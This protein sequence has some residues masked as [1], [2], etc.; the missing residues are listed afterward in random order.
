MPRRPS[1]RATPARN[2]RGPA[3]P[4]TVGGLVQHELVTLLDTY[5]TEM[6]EFHRKAVESHDAARDHVDAVRLESELLEA[7]L[8]KKIDAQRA[9]ID[10]LM[11]ALAKRT[12]ATP[13]RAE[14]LDAAEADTGS[15][16]RRRRRSLLYLYEYRVTLRY[17]ISR[18]NARDGDGFVD[19]E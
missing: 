6:A 16:A 17:R 19:Y 11:D 1:A 18:S 12:N 10:R 7:R 14:E 8:M 9:Y 2:E 5:L 3:R 4:G 15:V 13:P